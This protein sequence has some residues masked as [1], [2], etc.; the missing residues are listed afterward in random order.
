M[1]INLPG[2]YKARRIRFLELWMPDDAWRIKVYGIAADGTQPK[3]RLVDAAKRVAADRLT[4]VKPD[5]V[6]HGVGF[7][8]IHQGKGGCF[9]FIDWWSLV[10]LN[11]HL[12]HAPLDDPDALKYHL[13]NNPIACVWDLALIGHERDAWVDCV[14]NNPSGPD[15]DAYLA[16]RMSAD[17]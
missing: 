1:S 9:V 4:Q 3:P 5:A 11:H 8:G 17:I 7:L 13:P 2:A 16:R 15:L 12:Y 14:L 10:E 6:Q